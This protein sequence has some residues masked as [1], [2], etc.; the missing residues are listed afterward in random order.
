LGFPTGCLN[1]AP[2]L[3]LNLHFST[4]M[5]TTTWCHPLIGYM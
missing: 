3:I 4:L 2:S 1:T 5:T